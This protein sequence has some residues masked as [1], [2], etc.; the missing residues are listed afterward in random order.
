MGIVGTFLLVIVLAVLAH[1]MGVNDRIITCGL[2]VVAFGFPAAV[3]V[4][5]AVVCVMG[6]IWLW[7]RIRK[8]KHNGSV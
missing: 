3:G 2:Y 5:A 6:I 4:T 8:G 1:C 7:E